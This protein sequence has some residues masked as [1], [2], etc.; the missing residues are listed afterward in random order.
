VQ[1]KEASGTLTGNL[2]IEGNTAAPDITG[3][4]VFNN[5]IIKPAFLNNKLELKHETIQ[6]KKDGVYFNS[7]TM[8]DA[9]K[10]AATIDGV[11]SDETFLRFHFCFTGQ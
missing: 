11:G 8:L 10:H 3:E 2:S 5:A 9:N 1:L 6:L 7:F 4:L